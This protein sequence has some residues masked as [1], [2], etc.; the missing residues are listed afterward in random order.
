MGVREE[1][2]SA[3]E[4]NR[5][6]VVP[7]AQLARSLSV[8]RNA[9]WKAVESLKQAGHEIQSTPGGY[10]LD[11]RSD[12]LSAE[13]I[14]QYLTAPDFYQLNVYDVVDST[15]RLAKQL[16]AKG[17]PEGTV[18]VAEGQSGGRGRM[19]RA[20][21]SPEGTGAYFSIVFRPQMRAQEAQRLTTI[22]AV[23][24]CEAIGELSG[25]DAKIKWVN[26]VL[27]DGKKVCGI[28]TAASLDLESGGLEYAVVGIGLNVR[29]PIGGMPSEIADIAGAIFPDDAPGCA[30]SRLVA[31][32]LNRFHHYY[33]NPT[34]KG[35]LDAYR[36]RSAIL[37]RSIAVLLPGGTRRA[38]ALSIDED[39]ALVVQY[40]DGTQAKLS[41]GEV[42]TRL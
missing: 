32:V 5:G 21:H 17:N 3:L 27:I 11:E 13:A 1:V 18:L 6:H 42:S 34:K 4:I 10:R 22:A 35:W 2:L 40:A 30:R 31:E 7:G 33:A 39:C 38:L 15:N 29:P 24:V 26:D 23:A 19:G 14:G 9:V 41:S 12:R 37:G 28:L 20:F 25:R 8:S 16:A 36:A